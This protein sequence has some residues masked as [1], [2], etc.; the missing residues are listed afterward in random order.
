MTLPFG[1]SFSSGY[2]VV[3][4]VVFIFYILTS[5]EL[6]AKEIEDPLGSDENDLPTQN[7]L[8]TSKN[9]SKN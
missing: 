4:F 9:M 5:L 1:Y 6:I 3:P 2:Y 7:L 8:R